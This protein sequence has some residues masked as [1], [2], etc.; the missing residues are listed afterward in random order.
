LPSLPVLKQ[1]EGWKQWWNN[2]MAYLEV[3]ELEKFLTEDIPESIDPGKKRQWLKC[4]RF[5]MVHLLKAIAPD[6]QKDT[7]VF[8]L[9]H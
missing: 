7:E 8:G 4:R 1:E 9:G 5:I 3:L 6:V 2:V